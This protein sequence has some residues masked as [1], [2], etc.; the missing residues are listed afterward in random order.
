MP[1]DRERQGLIAKIRALPDSLEALVGGLSAEQLSTAYLAGEWTVAQNVHH[2]ADAHA[3]SYVRCKLVL[4]EDNPTFKP[5][6][7]DAWADLPDARDPDVGASLRLLQALHGRW[8][9]FWESLPDEA[10]ARAG[11]HPESGPMSLD[12]LLRIYAAHGEGHL[13]QIRRTL[14]A[15]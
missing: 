6:D 10:W 7:H 1:N 14:A 13:D 4:T 2:L 12:D 11:F 9:R 5:F 15:A 3:N 8:A